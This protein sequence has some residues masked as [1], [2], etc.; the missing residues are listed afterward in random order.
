MRA[1]SIFVLWLSVGLGVGFVL[2][3]RDTVPPT[4]DALEPADDGVERELI[5]ALRQARERGH[6]PHELPALAA[7][8][9]GQRT[10][11]PRDAGVADQTEGIFMLLGPHELNGVVGRR[12]EVS[13]KVEPGE[14][15]RVLG[16]ELRGLEPLHGTAVR[17]R[18]RVVR[19]DAAPE[20]LEPPRYVLDRVDLLEVDGRPHTQ[21]RGITSKRGASRPATGPSTAA[22]PL[23]DRLPP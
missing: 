12:V 7:R 15:P 19:V 6:A 2:R 4:L 9:L 18:G 20:A 21:V 5:E 1:L 22:A 3:L 23:P 17:A 8:S 14:V 13:G 16:L 11:E 10:D